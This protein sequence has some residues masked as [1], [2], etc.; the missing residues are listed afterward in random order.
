MGFRDVPSAKYWAYIQF[1]LGTG[2][3]AQ[4][5]EIK[6]LADSRGLRRVSLVGAAE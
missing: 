6:L 2:C 4:G 1:A 5:E 3:E